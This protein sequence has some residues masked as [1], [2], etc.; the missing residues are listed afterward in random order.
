MPLTEAIN[1]FLRVLA[2]RAIDIWYRKFV[3]DLPS[4][5]AYIASL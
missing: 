2:T 1:S 5:A 4:H 3:K